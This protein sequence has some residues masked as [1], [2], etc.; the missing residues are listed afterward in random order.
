MG[1]L[2]L[3]LSALSP[4]DKVSH[5]TGG[6][7]AKATGQQALRIHFPP[8][9]SVVVTDVQTCLTFTCLGAGDLNPGLHA[10]IRSVF[11]HLFISP[12]PLKLVRYL[13]PP[14]PKSVLHVPGPL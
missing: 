2:S 9:P 11:T 13:L 1:C 5:C 6:S 3:S 12:A 8:P 14:D 10:C 7:L 4:S